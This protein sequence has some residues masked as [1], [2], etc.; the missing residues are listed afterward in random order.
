MSSAQ[1]QHAGGLIRQPYQQHFHGFLIRP[2]VVSP[3]VV[4]T[5]VCAGD[6][7]DAAHPAHP[8]HLAAYI[9]II[10]TT[11]NCLRNIWQIP[12]QYKGLVREEGDDGLW[13]IDRS[14]LAIRAGGGWRI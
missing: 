3:S 4:M 13:A 2:I 8:A 7:P 12:S 1:Y 14:V 9:S 5:Q 10:R 6:V 11:V